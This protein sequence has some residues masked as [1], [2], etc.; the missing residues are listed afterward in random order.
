MALP[1]GFLEDLKFRNPVEDVISSYVSLKRAGSN[2]VGLCPFHN[3]KS[4]S[5][6]V[7]PATRGFYCFGCGA[8]GDVISFVMKAENLDY[9][10]AVEHLCKR[11]G[12][13]MP[14]SD[15]ELRRGTENDVKKSRIIAANRD[16]AR[17]YH[18][19]LSRPEGREGLAYLRSRGLTDAV[20][21]H[22]GLGFAPDEFALKKNLFLDHMKSLGY[23]ERELMAAFLCGKS[24]KNGRLY[25]YFRNRVMFPVIDINGEVVA[26]GGRVMD[27]SKPKY[28]NTSDTPAFKKS[29]TLFALNFARHSYADR[30]ILC[31][32][33]MDVIAVHAAGLPCA[34]A[35][36]GTAITSD[37]ARIMAR[38]T[39]EVV[40]AYDMDD[41][42]RRAAEKAIALLDSVG[43]RSKIL[44]LNGAK[45]P[46]EFIRKNGADAF[47]LRLDDSENQF[48]YRCAVVIQSHD[49][50]DFNDR[51]ACI[52]E[53]TQLLST[54][55]T[56]VEREVY[57]GRLA[58]RLEVSRESLK[59]DVQR[60]RKRQEKTKE[61]EAF[62]REVQK[63][64]GWGDR[65]NPD[66]GRMRR[67]A[68]AEEAI[69]GMLL[70]FPELF[71][72]ARAPFGGVPGITE[73]DFLT[74][75][76][77]RVFTFFAQ[78]MDARGRFDMGYLGEAFSEEEIGRIA[79]M[80]VTRAALTDNG[81][82]EL[83]S[84]LAALREEGAKQRLLEQESLSN[85]DLAALIREKRGKQ[86]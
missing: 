48:D 1:D 83:R 15:Y 31:E 53:L 46:D 7:F 70:L 77:R 73:D 44:K 85:E 63:T 22:F 41:A 51:M 4:P 2:L 9:I 52:S 79:G 8:G 86:Q 56:D 64:A 34:V 25:P 5:F 74:S 80:Q 62:R 50:T 28:L 37:Q 26:F 42:G 59:S 57:I 38:Y 78:C 67:A 76:N 43:I 16:A 82:A 54:L 68:A 60:L 32:G 55:H 69:L 35:T 21:R 72:D 13:E 47:R 18:E 30:L 81:T 65:I 84:N 12:I 27:D 3:E 17:F 36:L 14:Q 10:S 58:E 61:K 49:L 39:K 20:I 66:R 11:A 75:F 33:Y 71:S 6:T 45:D 19:M 24:Q 29:R 40:I 23:T